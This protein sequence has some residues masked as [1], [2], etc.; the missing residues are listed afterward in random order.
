MKIFKK[1]IVLLFAALSFAGMA[2]QKYPSKTQKDTL[3]EPQYGVSLFTGVCSGW[4]SP[5]AYVGAAPRFQQQINDQWKIKGGFAV[6]SDVADNFGRQP[7]RDLAPYRHPKRLAAA[8][9]SAEYHPTDRVWIS[10]TGFFIGGQTG[11]VGMNPMPNRGGL[12]ISAYGA[13]ISARFKVT[14]KSF[15][16]VNV[17]VV[18]DNTGFLAPMLWNPYCYGYDTY[19]RH[20]SIGG[21]INNGLL[22]F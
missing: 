15:V 9:V 7:A 6:M 1:Y 20:H 16:D 10:A 3:K 19:F 12:D 22:H 14:E 17:D 4:G 18:R 21:A 5:H 11:F 13:S 8:A 2:Q